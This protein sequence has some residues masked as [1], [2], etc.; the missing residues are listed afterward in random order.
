MVF[1]REVEDTEPDDDVVNDG[2]VNDGFARDVS[3][4][5]A[6]VSDRVGFTWMAASS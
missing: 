6:L 4:D 5:D 3:F 1:V 2:L